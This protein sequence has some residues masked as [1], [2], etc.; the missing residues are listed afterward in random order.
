M[1]VA[2]VTDS[3]AYL[4]ED[5][6]TGLGI[7]VVPLH[8]VVDGED[9]R[10]GQDISAAE[11]AQRLRA[12]ARVTTSRP[13]PEDMLAAYRRAAQA[14]ASQIVSA[15]LSSAV[16]ST[17]GSASLA[18]GQSPVPVT[19]LDTRSVAMAMGHSVVA[20]V[21]AA[22]RGSDA[23]AVAEVV[24]AHCEASTL[25]FCVDSLEYLRRGGRIGAASALVGSALAIKPL[26]GLRDGAIVPIE[27][28]RTS[29]KALTRLCERTVDAV[30]SLAAQHDWVDVAVHHL[31]A[32][33]RA[34]QVAETLAN[35]LP[36]ATR[37]RLVEIGPVIGAHAGPG[38]IGVS[39]TPRLT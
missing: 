20:G 31:D 6:V 18:A 14:G 24:R 13:S 7:Q 12:G 26:L 25:I 28:V 29:A 2:L 30:S 11:V 33:E 32:E 27:R 10:E 34:E 17:V 22:E 15:H 39:I 37:L 35:A 4:P 8:V 19:V 36:A 3:T 16:S 1:T 38:T 9:R 21:R 5:L 23:A